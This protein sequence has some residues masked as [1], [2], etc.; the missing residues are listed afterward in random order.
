MPLLEE[1]M[2]DLRSDTVTKPTPSMRE[3]MVNA[4]VGDDVY[5]DDPTVN[6]LEAAVADL[7]GKEAAVF[8]PTGSMSN[9]IAIRT[10]TEPGDLVVLERGA[11]IVRSEGGGGA[12]LSGVTMRPLDGVYGVFTAEQLAETIGRP[13]PFNPSTLLSPPTLLCIENTHNGAGGT[14]WPLDVM[15]EV[16]ESGRTHG[17]TLHLDGARLWHASAASGVSVCEY[18]EPFDTVNVCF[19]KGLGAPIGSALVGEKPFID[20][21]RRFKQQFGGG[22]RQSGIVA[23]AALHALEH[24]RDELRTDVERAAVLA[25]ALLNAPG[26]SVDMESVQSNI[27][28][29]EVE[30]EAGDFASECHSRGVYMLPNGEHGMRAV[31]H[32]DLTDED[33]ATAVETMN[34]VASGRSAF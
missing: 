31:L 17:M 12:A 23:A 19:S 5:A 33:V 34:E 30:M 1:L 4:V 16:C 3:A 10:H 27:V 8:V 6:K 29:F 9:Q 21:A 14:V 18:A 13:H 11:H 26:F 15:Q 28:R 7:L 2:I 32:R 20:R 24:H 25:G 22:M